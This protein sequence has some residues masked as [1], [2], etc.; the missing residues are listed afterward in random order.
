MAPRFIVGLDIGTSTIKVALGE[1]R[2]GK[3]ILRTLYQEPSAGLR[4]G[5]VWDLAEAVPAL[6]RAVEPIRRL[7]KSALK[8]IYS[9]ISSPQAKVQHQKGIIAVSRADN[10]IYQ[11]DIDRAVK[12]AQAINLPPNRM[13]V[14]VVIKEFIVDGV[15]DIAN[16]RGLS[17]NRLEVGAVLIDVFSPHGTSAGRLLELVGGEKNFLL[18][19]PLATAKA[20]LS[21][22]QKEL[23]VV[24]VDIGFGTTSMAVYEE[25]KLVGAQIFP[26]GSSNITNDLAVG[27]RIPVDAAENIKLQYGYALSSEVNSKESFELKKFVPE[28]KGN[29]S[30]RFVSEIIESRLAEIL[31]FVNNELKLM[32]RAGRLAG[33]AIFVG[34]GSKMPGLTELARQELKLSCQIGFAS[35]A[36]KLEREGD[37]ASSDM[38]EDPEFASSLGL[39]MS[40]MEREGWTF[41]DDKGFSLGDTVNKVKSWFGNFIPSN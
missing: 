36:E 28:A 1:F 31:E 39:L 40:G 30:R 16:P 2:N 12:A 37:T 23:G 35:V 8:V 9:N 20:V 3:I 41:K 19:N 29:I 4:K 7:N 6:S 15:A 22:H 13:L 26:V 18:F 38:V 32:G 24:L 5:A 34:G 11:D 14:E 27:L 25:N 17:G 21:K 33:G 10:E